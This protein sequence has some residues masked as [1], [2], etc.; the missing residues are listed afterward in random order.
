MAEETIKI[1]WDKE[2]IHK[3]LDLIQDVIKRMANNSFQVKAWLIGILTGL[4]A[5]KSD[6]LFGGAVATMTLGKGSV[7]GLNLLLLLPI[8]TFWY[9]DA[10]FLRTERLYI[11]IYN[12]VIK[13]RTTSTEHLYD[14][15]PRRFDG[16]V[17]SIYKI[18]LSK[19]LLPFYALP[20]VF[21]VGLF[22][23]NVWY[24]SANQP[25]IQSL[26]K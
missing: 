19:T 22:I 20:L 4:I 10:F 9:L 1:N 15:N 6:Q 14:L 25:F 2:V 23:F 13:N 7:L 18:M 24:N 26:S 21:V 5:I 16:N 12:W 11:Q 8:F 3:E 17:D